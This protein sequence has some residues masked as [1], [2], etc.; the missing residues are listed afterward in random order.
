VTRQGYYARE[1]RPPSA[2]K[3]ADRE[4][5]RRMRQMH[6]DSDEMY[7]APRVH[8]ELVVGNGIRVGK[9]RVARLIR[10]LGLRGADGRRGGVQTTTR[11]P[12]R[13]SAP[14]LVDRVFAR[15]APNRLWVADISCLRTWEGWVYIAVV[16]DC[17]S[18]RVVGR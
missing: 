14:D 5:A 8:S 10:Q 17:Y 3:L 6:A 7:G 2:R 12:E 9:K 11:D 16:V 13:A 15:S 1:R 4:L 18:R